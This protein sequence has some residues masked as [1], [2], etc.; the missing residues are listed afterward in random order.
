MI[1]ELRKKNRC[2]ALEVKKKFED[3]GEVDSYGSCNFRGHILL[4]VQMGSSVKVE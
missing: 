1:I 2:G 4:R 3:V